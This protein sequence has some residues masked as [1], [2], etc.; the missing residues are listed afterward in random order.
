MLIVLLV[1]LV[2]AGCVYYLLSLQARKIVSANEKQIQG[3][4]NLLDRRK[5]V[6]ERVNMFMGHLVPVD[7]MRKKVLATIESADILQAERGRMAITRVEL[8]SVLL[9][10]NEL[11]EIERELDASEAESREELNVLKNRESELRLRNEDLKD[12]INSSLSMLE[13]LRGEV[14]MTE[15]QRK[16]LDSAQEDLSFAQEQI[17]ELLDQIVKGNDHYHRLK[18]RYDA[19]DIEYAQLYEK[20]IGE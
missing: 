1:G 15:E 3:L 12:E 16:L 2:E 8:D 11:D 13:K 9:R 14:A 19:L 17:D 20:F 4:R 7:E 6:L 18:R 5:E 10:L